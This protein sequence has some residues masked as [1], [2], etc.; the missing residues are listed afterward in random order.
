MTALRGAM[1]ELLRQLAVGAA[2]V[3]LLVVALV[4]LPPL[5]GGEPR[6]ARNEVRWHGWSV[7]HPKVL[8]MLEVAALDAPPGSRVLWVLPPGI[9]R[10]W[11]EVRA[12]YRLPATRPVAV[13]ERGAPLPSMEWDLRIDLYRDGRVVASP[14]D[15]ASPESPSGAGSSPPGDRS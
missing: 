10:R 5:A 8:S 9:D 12:L 6:T 4:R 14:A 15:P 11:F 3:A 2:L 1:N 13:V 7:R